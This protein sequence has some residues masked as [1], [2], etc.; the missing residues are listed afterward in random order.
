MAVIDRNTGETMF[1][2][3]LKE[4][5]SVFPNVSQQGEYVCRVEDVYYISECINEKV[6]DPKNRAVLERLSE[7]DNPVLIRYKL[8]P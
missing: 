2:R 3:G 4:G 7:E 6:L 5:F 1:V 8:K